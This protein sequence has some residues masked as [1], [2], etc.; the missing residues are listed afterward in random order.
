MP[1]KLNLADKNGKTWKLE[2]TSETLIGK[3]VGENLKGSDISADLEGYELII[4]GASDNAGFPHKKDVEGP[5]LKRVLLTKGWGMHKRPRREGK[6]KRYTPKGLRLRKTVRG[7]RLSEKTSQINL[8]ITKHGHKKLAEMFP[9]QNK[10]KEKKIE[11]A[12]TA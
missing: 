2:S 8:V 3:H 9:D 12:P 4:A 11:A 7:S 6:K 1:F 10:P 5:E